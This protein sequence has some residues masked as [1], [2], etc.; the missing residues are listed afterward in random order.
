[1]PQLETL[2][3]RSHTDRLALFGSFHQL[4]RR[5]IG[6]R[7]QWEALRVSKTDSKLR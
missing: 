3:I 4:H 1:M 5:E 7:M 2:P 6:L